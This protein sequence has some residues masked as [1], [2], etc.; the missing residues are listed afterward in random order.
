MGNAMRA[1][2]V[3]WVGFLLV[4]AACP[5]GPREVDV[6]IKAAAPVADG[7]ADARE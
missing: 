4:L 1:L 2:V 7:G 6:I 3:G 5:G